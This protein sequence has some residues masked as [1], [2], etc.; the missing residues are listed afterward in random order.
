[1]V[2][3]TAATFTASCFGHENPPA[4]NNA[5]RCT[6][7]LTFVNI[8]RRSGKNDFVKIIFRNIRME[9]RVRGTVIFFLFRTLPYFFPFSYLYLNFVD[10]DLTVFDHW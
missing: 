8:N 1:M 10:T 3:E 9:T 5:S 7:A 2:P 4:M 6:H